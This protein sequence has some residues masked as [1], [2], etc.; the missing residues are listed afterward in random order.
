MAKD[1]KEFLKDTKRENSEALKDMIRENRSAAREAG[2]GIDMDCVK[3]CRSDSFSCVSDAGGD[4][5]DLR[6]CA[7]ELLGCSKECKP[8][9]D[10]LKEVKAENT[11]NELHAPFETPEGVGEPTVVRCREAQPRA[12]AHQVSGRE[13]RYRGV[14]RCPPRHPRRGPQRRSKGVMR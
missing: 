13:A 5:A 14:R 11:S 4:R 10:D 9:S 3:D 7:R 2:C 1:H 8:S 6:D 12:C